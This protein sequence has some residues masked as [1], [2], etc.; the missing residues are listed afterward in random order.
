[1]RKVDT[2]ILLNDFAVRSFRDVADRDYISARMNYKAG[3]FSQ[4]LW[5]SLQAIEKYL[6]GILLLNRVPA[7]NVGHDL[8]KAIDLISKH[9]PFE[10]R[11]DAAQR[12]F[13]DH[14]DTYGRFRYLETSYFIHGNELWLLDSTVWAVRRY[15]R[16]MNYNLPIG[17]GGGR[18]MLEVE[19]KANIDAE[20]T[21]HQFRIM[22]GEL[23]KIIGNRK[24]PARK[25]L[26]WLNAHYA[27][28]T[29]KQM[30]VPRCFH[31]TNSPLSLRPHILK[32]VLKYVFL[33][34]DVVQAFQEKL[35]KEADK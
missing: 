10:L 25:H 20:R 35:E 28:R 7:K 32:E 13:I 21:P 4:F 33:P 27:T 14:L 34:R 12:K 15:C 2:E 11:L 5:S 30:R 24:N 31:A 19:I 17:K 8:G 9:A 6:K 29:R 3:L 23:E 16:V 1:M 18:N 26:L 22:S